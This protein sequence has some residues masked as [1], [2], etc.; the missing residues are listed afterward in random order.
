MST[1]SVITIGKSHLAVPIVTRKGELEERIFQNTYIQMIAQQRGIETPIVIKEMAR[2]IEAESYAE[3]RHHLLS[4]LQDIKAS[5]LHL[6]GD[7]SYLPLHPSGSS[8]SSVVFIHERLHPLILN[9]VK[10]AEEVVAYLKAA[11]T[12]EYCHGRFQLNGV[13]LQL[14]DD[15]TRGKLTD[16]LGYISPDLLHK[17][18]GAKNIVQFRMFHRNLAKSGLAKGL[19]KLDMTLPPNTIL[20]SKSQVKGKVD[21][22][23][24]R[25]IKD[26][27]IGLLRRFEGNPSSAAESYTFLEFHHHLRDKEIPMA[28]E[29]AK[30]LIDILKCPIRL[31]EYQGII[32]REPQALSTVDTLLKICVG[33]R[34]MDSRLPPIERHPYVVT[35]VTQIMASQL[36]HL[37]TSGSRDWPYPV[38]SEVLTGEG[39]EIFIKTKLFPV[40]TE[41]AIARYPLLEGANIGYGVVME[42]SDSISEVSIGRK[43]AEITN[44]DSDGDC[45]LLMDEPERVAIAKRIHENPHERISKNHTR[46][47]SSLFEL[48]DVIVKNLFSASIGSATMAMVACELKGDVANRRKMAITV[49]NATDSIKFDVDN[50]E[51]RRRAKE[52]LDAYGL[53]DHITHRN[54]KKMFAGDE[55][56]DF[57]SS[58][59]WQEIA[60]YYTTEMTQIKAES[61]P[62]RAYA[63]LFGHDAFCLSKDQLKELTAVY[64]WYCYRVRA[65]HD[66][67]LEM[68]E[69]Y[70]K[71]KNLIEIL[72]AWK[73][74]LKGDLNHHAC[75][76]WSLVHSST[77]KRNIG[78]FVFHVFR[79][80]IMEMLLKVYDSVELIP[81]TPVQRQLKN[82]INDN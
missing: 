59:L 31:S 81:M 18:G 45:L 34:R 54:N 48:N 62:L 29:K 1:E 65:I 53:P 16:G 35:N 24:W 37:A 61:L 40:G 68:E 14:K 69:R 36:R 26:M 28:I 78:A 32:D 56:K 42:E 60:R 30:E 11:L 10:C 49:Q 71:F 6:E 9:T 74:Q 41:L 2:P 5:E 58:P 51:G 55:T 17:L 76:A 43:I 52:L 38:L 27:D 33:S 23:D 79:K 19:L 15:E 4:Q 3:Y 80:E 12:T 72:I 46:L 82:D 57:D 75:A 20:L 39:E 70:E 8:R 77:D 13:N 7:H 22:M 63:G 21:E 67:E 44:S 64:R 50:R 47:H 73:S 66:Q 25:G